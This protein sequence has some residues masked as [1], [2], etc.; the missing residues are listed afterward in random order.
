ME[1][2]EMKKLIKFRTLK[3]ICAYDDIEEKATYCCHRLTTKEWVICCS[4]NCPV[5]K[6]LKEIKK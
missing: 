6:K 4:K 5:W 1:E 2:R 3:S